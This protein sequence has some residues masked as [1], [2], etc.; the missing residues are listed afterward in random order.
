MTATNKGL[1]IIYEDNHL[2]V[3]L[4]EAN[5]LSQKDKTDDEDLLSILKKYLKDK[6]KT[7]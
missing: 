5:I 1:K 4:K 7:R 6:T 3:V 2:L